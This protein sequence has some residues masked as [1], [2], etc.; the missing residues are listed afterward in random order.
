[1]HLQPRPMPDPLVRFAAPATRSGK[2]CAGSV[3]AR[4]RYGEYALGSEY[5]GGLR[6]PRNNS[7]A[8]E[9]LP[10]RFP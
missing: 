2:W 6:S 10:R 3:V 8:A 5:A 4:L 9:S 7:A 1:M